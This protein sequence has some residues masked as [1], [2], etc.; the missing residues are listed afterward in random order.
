MK[1]SFAAVKNGELFD[2]SSSGCIIK[3][4]YELQTQRRNFYAEPL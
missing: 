1:K 4:V 2:F 3:A